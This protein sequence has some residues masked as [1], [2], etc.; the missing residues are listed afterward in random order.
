MGC[1][2]KDAET[3]SDLLLG[4]GGSFVTEKLVPIKISFSG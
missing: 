2:C 1:S 4:W 3:S